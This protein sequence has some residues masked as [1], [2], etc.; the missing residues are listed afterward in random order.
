MKNQMPNFIMPERVKLSARKAIHT[1]E[2]V[3][4]TYGLGIWPTAQEKEKWLHD[5]ALFLFYN[6]LCSV[7]L[8]LLGKDKTVVAEV[9][10]CFGQR[11]ES[12]TGGAPAGTEVPLIDKRLVAGH[13]VLVHQRQVN[14]EQYRHLLKL[15]WQTAETLRRRRGDE[16]ANNQARKTGGRQTGS[17]FTSKEARHELTITRPI[18]PRGY[19]FCDCPKLGL[20][21]VFLHKRHLCGVRELKPGQRVS[22]VLIQLPNG[23]QA[24]EV[25]TA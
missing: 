17:I 11:V 25:R 22:G 19:G 4:T 7:S 3:D 9:K 5:L 18:G 16:F 6:N 21:G 24:R 10:V 15:N 14:P 8:E 13:R 2:L 23:F 1:L 20:T 12:T